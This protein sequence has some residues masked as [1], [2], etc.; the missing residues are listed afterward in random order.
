MSEK[1]NLT[2][3]VYRCQ[4]QDSV[5]EST[6]NYFR[7]LSVLE[8]VSSSSLRAGGSISLEGQRFTTAILG[9]D[10][11]RMGIAGRGQLLAF[12]FDYLAIFPYSMPYQE[13]LKLF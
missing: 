1:S 6:Q 8:I 12:L 5:L 10:P 3:P 7:S 4:V 13:A 9:F 11:V 2:K